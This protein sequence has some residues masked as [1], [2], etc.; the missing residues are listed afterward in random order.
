VLGIDDGPFEKGTDRDVPI[1]AVVMEGAGV[2]EGVSISS[3]PVDGE[4]ATGFLV[5]WIG[6]SR[7]AP[8]LQGVVLGGVALA[9]L[10]VIDLAALASA[11]GVPVLSVTRRAPTETG[12]QDALTAAGL[13]HRTAILERIP[14][15]Q[16]VEPGLFLSF[17]GAE[18]DEA[19]DLLRATLGASKMPEALR[20]AHLIGAA[21]VR[22]HSRGRA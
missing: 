13:S 8:A 20:V 14:T 21:L 7:W 16:E 5:Q 2:I 22:G 15:A 6:G 12:L 3:F 11:L 17:A 9:G 19:R 18:R 1:V 10:G 4:N